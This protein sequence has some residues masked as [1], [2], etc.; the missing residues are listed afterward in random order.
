MGLTIVERQAQL[1]ANIA[2]IAAS[3]VERVT[4]TADAM[5][6]VAQQALETASHAAESAGQ[7]ELRARE[8]FDTL[9]EELCIK[10]DEDCVVNETRRGQTEMRMVAL[11]SSIE[12]KTNE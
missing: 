7:S 12:K 11:G 4:A 8:L 2:S 9:R 6:N 5:H 10:F 1:V 3:D